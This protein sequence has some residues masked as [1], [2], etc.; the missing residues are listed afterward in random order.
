MP[1][2]LSATAV[3][4]RQL[5]VVDAAGVVT[6]L[7]ARVLVTYGQQGQVE[8]YDLWANLTASQRTAFQAMYTRLLAQ[9][10]TT[11]IT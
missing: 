9:L 7:T 11:Y 3:V 2:T 8:D 5:D 10:T 1:K 4:L 6:G